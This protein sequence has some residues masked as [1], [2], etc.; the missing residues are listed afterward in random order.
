MTNLIKTLR[1]PIFTDA[2]GNRWKYFDYERCSLSLTAIYQSVSDPDTFIEID[3]DFEH[4]ED[5]SISGWEYPNHHSNRIKPGE[6][7][8]DYGRA[9]SE[10]LSRAHD[11][12]RERREA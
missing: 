8:Y 7:G 12:V 4:Q 5:E 1:K 9:V 3:V 11:I 2:D 10:A 6:N